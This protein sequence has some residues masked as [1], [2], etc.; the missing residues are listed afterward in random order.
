MAPTLLVLAAQPSWNEE[1]IE[2]VTE[3]A[4][5][6]EIHVM[7]G[8]SHFLMMERPRQFHA[9]VTEFLERNGIR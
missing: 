9:L 3:L 8:V 5:R 6:A 7:Q 2:F 1:Y 4:P